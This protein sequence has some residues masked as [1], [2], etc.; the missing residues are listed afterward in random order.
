MIVPI[1]SYG[2]EIWACFGWRRPEIR[3]IKQFIFDTR[4]SFKKLQSKMRR[5]AL[6]INKN[7]PDHWVKAE[8]GAFPIMGF[9]IKRILSY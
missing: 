5:N 6:G 7:V 3:N 2:A 8:M 9:Y 1:L 4:H